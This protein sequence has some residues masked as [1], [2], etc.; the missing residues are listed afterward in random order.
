[1]PHLPGG[2]ALLAVGIVGATVMPH[3][4]YLHSALTKKRIVGTS[5]DARRRIFRFEIVDVSIAMGLAGVVNLA[6][7][8]TAASVFWAR[9]LT[10]AGGDLGQ[11]F[12]GL[13]RYL[14]AHTGLVFGVALLASGLASSCV[15]TMSGQV[16]MEGFIHR[17]IPVF[18]RRAITMI[19]ALV[20]IAV[21]FS[22]TR[23]LV[24]SQVFL[25]FGIPFA[26]VPLVVFT[27][28]RRLMGT[29]ANRP[30]TNLAAYIVVAM[31][32]GLNV[33]LLMAAIS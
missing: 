31:I 12:Q 22:P 29:L 18:A 14:G 16:V 13:N 5:A 26:L 6:M 28:D 9:G 10:G 1:V 23:A 30:A 4:I 2:S 7:L 32:I 19:P 33:Y 25:S 3:V 11:V 17:Q 15:G 20:L 27:R 8:A 21:G 24:L